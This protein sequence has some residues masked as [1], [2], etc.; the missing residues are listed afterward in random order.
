MKRCAATSRR[1]STFSAG[2]VTP[3][4]PCGHKDMLVNDHTCVIVGVRIEPACLVLLH[5]DAA[6]AAIACKC[7]VPTSIVMWEVST[8]TIIGPPPA[9]MEVE[10]APMVLHREVNIGIGVPERRPFWFRRLEDGRGLTK[11]D[12]PHARR[13]RSCILPS[14]NAE[15]VDQFTI[16]VEPHCLFDQ[17]HHNYLA[18]QTVV[19]YQL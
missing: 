17:G 7:L 8:G 5:V 9:I 19:L 3:G 4:T 11:Q 13:G 6:V 1:A 14:G 12:M 18:G 15:L 10:A 16:L 2:T